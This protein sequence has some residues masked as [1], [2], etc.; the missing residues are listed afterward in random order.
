M[1]TWHYTHHGPD[2]CE[3]AIV[4]RW[5]EDQ[6]DVDTVE[7]VSIKLCKNHAAI[8]GKKNIV[9]NDRLIQESGKY[10]YQ[11]TMRD[12]AGK[13]VKTEFVD[14]FDAPPS[15]EIVSA[16]VMD[17]ML[18]P[19][20]ENQMKNKLLTQFAVI[21]TSVDPSN[22]RPLPYTWRFDAS[23]VLYIKPSDAAFWNTAKKNQLR[24]LLDANYGHG[25]IVVE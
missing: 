9:C 6:P 13:L 1:V 23:R 7:Y 19:V 20:R 11:R 2:T 24:T 5:D 17:Q 18:N 15:E 3:C 8:L 12:A 4:F 25:K 10:G 21:D 14:R 16:A 22:L